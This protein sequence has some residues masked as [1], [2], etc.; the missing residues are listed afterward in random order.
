LHELGTVLVVPHIQ[1]REATTELQS[2]T[3]RAHATVLNCATAV[4]HEAA[5]LEVNPHLAKCTLC[6][7]ESYA[8]ATR[9]AKTKQCPMSYRGVMPVANQLAKGIHSKR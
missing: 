4:V 8:S 9:K 7:R 3:R 6:I 2:D 5:L 1:R